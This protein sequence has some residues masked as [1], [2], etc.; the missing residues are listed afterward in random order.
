MSRMALRQD[1][2]EWIVYG[3]EERWPLWARLVV[4]SLCVIV[5]AACWVVGY[6]ALWLLSKGL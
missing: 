3:H 4:L 6:Y 5:G 2:Y 1:D